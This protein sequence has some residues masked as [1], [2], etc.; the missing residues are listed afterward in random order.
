MIGPWHILAVALGGAAGALARFGVSHWL[1]PRAEAFPL[2]TFLVNVAGCFGIGFC[3]VAFDEAFNP[4]MR[5]NLILR[6]GVRVGFLGGLTTF[7]TFAMESLVLLERQHYGYAALN[8]LGS[9]AAGLA[10]AALGMWFGKMAF[11]A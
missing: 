3:F 10:A 1:N 9:V 6:D 2:A 5:D 8:L 7:S 4:A 11:H